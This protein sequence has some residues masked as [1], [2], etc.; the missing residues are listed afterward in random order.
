[1]RLPMQSAGIN[2]VKGEVPK[3]VI[4]LEPS[5]VGEIKSGLWCTGE[6]CDSLKIAC[7]NGHASYQEA[8]S[9]KHKLGWCIV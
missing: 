6:S 7:E 1:M 8:G 5:T 9:G 4:A 3:L 2:P